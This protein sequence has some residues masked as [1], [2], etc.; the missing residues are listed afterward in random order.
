MNQDFLIWKYRS[1][2][3]ACVLNQITGTDKTVELRRGLPLRADFPADVGLHM[4]PDFPNDIALPDNVLNSDL[5][6]VVSARLR[7]FLESR[8]LASVEYLPV[9]IIDHKGRPA[10]TEY[11]I[12]H[13]IEPV[14]CI[15]R[16]QSVF[17]ENKIV[18]GAIRSMTKLA[19]DAARIPANRA[20]FKL[21][22]FS[23]ITLVRRELAQA[24][25]QQNFSGLGWTEIAAYPEK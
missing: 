17:V 2:P 9:A 25:D 15:D 19:I 11:F 1:V 8:D 18:K 22:G 14:D 12:A 6:N 16:Q 24:L 3:H 10:S 5:L 7:E 23:D 20:M 4:H 21:K 13:P